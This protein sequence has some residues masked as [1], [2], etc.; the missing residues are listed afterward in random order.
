[1]YSYCNRIG[2]NASFGYIQEKRLILKINAILPK[3]NVDVHT[4][5]V[6]GDFGTQDN[7]LKQVE[8][9]YSTD[10]TK[11]QTGLMGKVRNKTIVVQS[12]IES[13][14]KRTLFCFFSVFFLQ[15]GGFF[16]HMFLL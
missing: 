11:I 5:Y 4:L 10:V 12:G 13:F 1:M 14:L 9:K 3:P 6:D 7:P 16:V 8:A 15:I 2:A